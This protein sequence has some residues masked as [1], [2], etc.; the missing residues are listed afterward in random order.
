MGLDDLGYFD[1]AAYRK[2][3]RNLSVSELRKREIIKFR[4]HCTAGW[5]IGHGVV[6][7][8]VRRLEAK[9]HPYSCQRHADLLPF[10]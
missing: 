2:K 1:E 6:L 7:A 8:V 9:S 3:V 5:A 4:Q 10:T